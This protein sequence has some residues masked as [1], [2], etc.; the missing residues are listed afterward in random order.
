MLKDIYLFFKKEKRYFWLVLG[1]LV[2]YAFLFLE[3][4][5]RPQIVKSSQT[6]TSFKEA[7]AKWNEGINRQEAFMDFVK[8]EPFLA[9][10]FELMTLGFVIAF[11][12]GC[13][14]D[15]VFLMNPRFREK[16]SNSLSPP[17]DRPWPFSILFKVIILF[18]FW[19]IVISLLMGFFEALFPKKISGNFYMI[20]HTLILNLLCLY[21][22][23]RFVRG[24][25]GK[26]QD[27]GLTIPQTG[28]F[29]EV[30]AGVMGYLGILPLFAV[31][32]FILFGIA[33]WSQYEP[34]AH[35]LAN[36]FLEESKR[37]PFLILVSVILG[38]VLGPVFEEIFFRGFCYPIFKN[39][40]GK[41]WGMVLSAAFF[42]GIHHSGFVFWP[43]FML[44]VTL[45][46]LYEKRRSLIASMTLHVIH[47]TIFISY[48]FLV[49]QI[50]GSTPS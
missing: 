46:Y 5:P 33:H 31:A 2:F 8:R 21:F 30:K 36:V 35:P 47:N 18:M 42:A 43:I 38:T 24:L 39:K 40:W 4:K 13:I 1:I 44:G 29:R 3:S 16:W 6:A 28:F 20:L 50:L 9:T 23:V 22:M 49:K 32:L 27:L 15:T 26:G 37:A 12:A 11:I 14:I 25:G 19:G 45:A 10:L 17:S 34:P 7:E 41:I 48:F